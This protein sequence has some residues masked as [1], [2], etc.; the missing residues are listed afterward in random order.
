MEMKIDFPGGKKVTTHF[1]NR[2]IPTDQPISSGGD[3]TAPAPFDLFLASIGACAGF[4]VLAFCDTRKIPTDE[5][6]LTM[7][8]KRDPEKKLIT[9]MDIAIHLPPE[10]PEKYH[11][12]VIKAAEYC[13]GARHLENPP[14]IVL[15]VVPAGKT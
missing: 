4:Y 6:S 8:T 15:N 3:G 7:T 12:A 2:S 5:L 14:A 1:H 13:T 10:F 11:K 9:Q